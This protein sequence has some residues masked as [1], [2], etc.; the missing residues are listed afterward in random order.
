ME[1]ETGNHFIYEEQPDGTA[2]LRIGCTRSGCLVLILVIA[3]IVT[4]V[5]L[6][7]SGVI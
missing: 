3:V 1:E 7:R 2:D 4:L 6:K 5:A